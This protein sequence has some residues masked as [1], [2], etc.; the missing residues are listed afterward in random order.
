[1]SFVSKTG[2]LRYR[3]HMVSV[4]GSALDGYGVVPSFS[5]L[6]KKLS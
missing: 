2:L 6:N 1:M 3:L 4:A 5:D